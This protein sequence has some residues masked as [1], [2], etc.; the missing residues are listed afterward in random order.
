MSR[1]ERDPGKPFWIDLDHDYERASDGRS[2]YGAYIRERAGWFTDIGTHQ[3]TAEFAALAWRIATS[4]IMSPPLVHAHPRIIS[5]VLSRSN[6]DGSLCAAVSVVAPLP[7]QLHRLRPADGGYFRD[8]NTGLF[9]GYEDVGEQD[10]ATAPY[11]L[12]TVDLHT[13]IALTDVPAIESVPTG[14]LLVYQGIA[15]IESLLPVLNA[16]VGPLI[17]ALEHSRRHQCDT[18]RPPGC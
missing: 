15:V 2:R 3:P 16:H 6:Y 17:E 11:L 10:L 14:Q 12:T 18:A 9:G 4:P 13:T 7:Q 5:A 1:P 8:W